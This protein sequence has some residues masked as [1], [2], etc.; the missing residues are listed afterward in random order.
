MFQDSVW[1]A[2]SCCRSP[3]VPGVLLMD[4]SLYVH[5]LL[6]F[7]APPWRLPVA[8]A[9][10]R[11]DLAV[12]ASDEVPPAWRVAA[13]RPLQSPYRPAARQF[14]PPGLC[15]CVRSGVASPRERIAAVAPRP[16]HSSPEP[17]EQSQRALRRDRYRRPAAQ[18]RF[19]SG[20]IHEFAWNAPSPEIL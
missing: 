12:A 10:L 8:S 9:P 13:T 14:V 18:Y 19:G 5:C 17:A 1:S 2:D 16:L 6:T 7:Q 15:A 20:E 11:R 3:T 4:V